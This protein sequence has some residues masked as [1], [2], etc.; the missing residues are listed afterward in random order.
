M[1]EGL[2]EAREAFAQ[3][4][5]QATR[6]RDQAGKFVSTSSKPEP[7]FQPR[8][9]EG[10]DRGDTSDGGADPRLLEQERR[11]A[12]G[13][14]EEGDAVSKPA[15]R[16]AAP[17]DDEHDTTQDEPPERIGEGA[18]DADP[19]AEKPDK[20]TGP[21]GED[22]EDA[23]PRYKIQVDGEEREVS[24]NEA[25][26][27]YQREET[28]NHR[29]RQMVEVA[30]TIDQRGAQAQQAREA[31]IQLC[32]NQEQEFAALIPK[33]PDWDALYKQDPA[34]AH[35][36]EQNYKAVYGTLNS[37]RQRRA[38]AQ[39]DAYQ[40]HAQQTAS[41]ARA[42]FD[43]FRAKH[44]LSDQASVD[45]AIGYMRRTALEAG[46]SDDEIG[47]T[48]DERMLTVLH[49]A[50]RFDNMMR[51]KPLPVQPERQ[52]ALQPGSAPRIGNGAQRGMNDAMKRLQASGRVDDAAGVFAQMLRGGR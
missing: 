8:D 11:V 10:D 13:R 36:L 31:Y 48:Y 35:Q 25:L 32:Q 6:P 22:G 20:G 19:N 21:D 1:P 40:A 46:F 49:K 43:K 14:S 44:K 39:A 52:G 15:K 42:E 33:E 24:L 51:N 4:I 23:S 12:D 7:I 2:D 47:T 17:A 26:R 41:Y 37:I 38:Q 18:D 29:M 9:V 28:F 34:A 45:K 50:A 30:K 5:P 27:G 16:N 3:E